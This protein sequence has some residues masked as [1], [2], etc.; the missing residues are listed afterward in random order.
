MVLKV[1]D[2]LRA[3][4]LSVWIDEDDV[5]TLIESLSSIVIITLSQQ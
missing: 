1:R 4:G 2:R 3:A 5:C